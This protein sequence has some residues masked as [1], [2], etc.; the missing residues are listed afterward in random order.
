MA[1]AGLGA[2]E[3][4]WL[5]FG[6]SMPW[7]FGEWCGKRSDD[8]KFVGGDIG[9]ERRLMSGGGAVG[10]KRRAVSFGRRSQADADL[11]GVTTIILISSAVVMSSPVDLKFGGNVVSTWWG[12]LSS[13]LSSCM[14]RKLCSFVDVDWLGRL[15]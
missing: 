2:V 9:G 3:G 15:L 8:M 13:L 10:A 4:S 12:K 7:F 11:D 5:D 14:Y 1:G 6:L